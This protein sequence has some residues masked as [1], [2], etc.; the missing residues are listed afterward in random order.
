[1]IDRL[2]S[3]IWKCFLIF[4]KN[5]G[6]TFRWNFHV[7]LFLWLFSSVSEGNFFHIHCKE[8][9]EV[10]FCDIGAWKGCQTY[11]K[12]LFHMEFDGRGV[13]VKIP[14]WWADMVIE[15][16]RIVRDLF[17]FRAIYKINI[18]MLRNLDIQ[19]IGSST[20]VGEAGFFFDIKIHTNSVKMA[21][22]G[23]KFSFLRLF[24]LKWVEITALYS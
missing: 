18:F 11:D 24:A 16:F 23:L 3:F 15:V 8:L 20:R 5:T 6:L 14:M 2:E 1:M 7:I 10:L 21:N 17:T 19:M 4:N 13:C 22:M 9:G 12:D